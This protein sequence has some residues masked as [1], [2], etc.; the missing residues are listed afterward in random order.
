MLNNSWNK[1]IYKLWSPVY[2]KIFNSHLFLDARKRMFEE[3]D[4]HDHAKVLFVGVGTEADLQLIKNLDLQ[5]NRNRP[6]AGYAIKSH[7]EI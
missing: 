4:F 1:V 3:L 2:D 5:N 6:V 7:E